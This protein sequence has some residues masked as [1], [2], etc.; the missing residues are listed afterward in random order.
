MNLRKAALIL[1]AVALGTCNQAIRVAPPGSTMEL[2]ANPEF[3]A[4][5]GDVS[6][7]SGLL[8]EPDGQPVVDGT[9]VQ[10]FTNLG[11][12]DEQGKTNDGV[13]RVNLVSDSRSGTAT[14]T[15]VSGGG[16]STTPTPSPSTTSERPGV[17]G[18]S[19]TSPT[20][21]SAVTATEASAT[22][23]VTIGS[24]RPTRLFL[25]ANPP[26]ITGS[27]ST[28]VLAEVFDANGNPVANVP[29]IFTI[30]GNPSTE[31]FLSGGQPVFTDNDGR[32]EDVLRT[33]YD[34]ALAPKTVTVRATTANGITATALVTIN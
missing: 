13:V 7:I 25:S 1:L 30:E 22:V 17:V 33:S 6:I 27:R 11:R 16:S 28:T 23:T 5:H 2:H 32:A 10:F 24:A 19:V 3:I 12:I 26:R 15:A 14:V 34:P 31:R 29:V 8:I 21:A 9:V 4:A 20:G 18:F